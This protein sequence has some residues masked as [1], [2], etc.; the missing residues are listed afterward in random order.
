MGEHVEHCLEG[1]HA[2]GGG[3]GNVEHEAPPYRPGPP[4]GEATEWIDRS[5]GLCESR[6]FPVEHGQGAFGSEISGTEAGAPG[7]HHEPAESLGRDPQRIGNLAN[8]IGNRQAFRDD[9]PCCLE[10]AHQ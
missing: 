1:L 6:S 2:T 9:E 10:T 3:A 7:R 5:H 8:A 4:T